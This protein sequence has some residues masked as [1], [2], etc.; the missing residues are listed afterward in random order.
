MKKNW[1]FIFT[2]LVTFGSLLVSCSKS[3]DETPIDTEKP[4]IQ[5]VSPTNEQVFLTGETISFSANFS[6]NV[7]LSSYKIDIHWAGG[8]DHKS[9]NDSVTWTYQKS[10][11]FDAGLTTASISHNEVVIPLEVDGKMVAPGAYH[12]L[13]YCTDKAGNESFLANSIDIEEP[14]DTEAPVIEILQAP[15]ELEVFGRN[16]TIAIA[17]QVTDAHHLGSLLVTLMKDNQT[18]ED[19]NVTDAFAIVLNADEQVQEQNSYDFQSYIIVSSPQDN[20][21][22]PRNITWSHGVFYLVVKAVDEAGNVSFSAHYPIQ[23]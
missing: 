19:V 14:A 21:V 22:P 10:W 6:D 9:T 13:V 2:V 5:I 20:N 23:L 4:V 8:H 11:N 12:F 7:E 15:G 3:E 1:L 16:D 17:G 18:D